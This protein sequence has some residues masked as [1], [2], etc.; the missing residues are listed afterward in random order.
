[1]PGFAGCPASVLLIGPEVH[2]RGAASQ[3]IIAAPKSA[4]LGARS[5]LSTLDTR[6]STLSAVADPTL[7]SDMPY[8]DILKVFQNYADYDLVGSAARA[9]LYIHAG[10]MMLA[11]SIRR[12]AQSSRAEEIE[13]EPEILER[14]V[15]TA[16]KWLACF[17]GS[18]APPRQIVPSPCWRD[19]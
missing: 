12:S 5:R 10:R 17:V 13:L 14:Q 15:K 6:P 1:M 9:R 2:L 7:S 4:A 16:E 3:R 11:F 19:E 8:G 18:T